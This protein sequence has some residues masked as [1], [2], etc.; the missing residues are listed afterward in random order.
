MRGACHRVVRLKSLPEGSEAPPMRFLPR[1][2]VA[3]SVA[4]LA[5]VTTG[6]LASPSTTGPAQAATS[7]GSSACL[8]YSGLDNPRLLNGDPKADLVGFVMR[9][10]FKA[11]GVTATVVG[12]GKGD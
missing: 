8:G 12:N 10:G 5:L 7:V 11:P 6:V 9:D 4:S 1:M 3:T 2:R